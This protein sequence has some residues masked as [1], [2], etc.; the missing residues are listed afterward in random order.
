MFMQIDYRNKAKRLRFVHHADHRAHMLSLS[1]YQI[2]EI[3]NLKLSVGF[4][5]QVVLKKQLY[6]VE[7]GLFDVEYIKVHVYCVQFIG[8]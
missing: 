7:I 6:R 4:E 8:L 2:R 1:H 5:G 3:A